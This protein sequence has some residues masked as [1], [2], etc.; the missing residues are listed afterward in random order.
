LRRAEE[1]RVADTPAYS[2]FVNSTDNFEDTWEPFFH[3]LNDFWPQ[4]R[5]VILNTERKTFNHPDVPVTCTKVAREGETRIPWGEC[6][7][8]ALEHISTETFVYL[9]DDYFLYRAVKTDVVDEAART[10]DAENL[11]CLR[12]MECG[13]AGPYEPTAYPWLCSVSR[14]ATYRISLQAALWTKAGMRKYLRSHESPWQMEVWGSKRA[15]RTEGRIWAVNR[16]VYSENHTQVI[17]Y[18]PTGIVRGQWKRDIVEK[19]FAEHGIDVPFDVRGWLTPGGPPR[20]SFT[21][22]L[23][24]LPKFAWDRVRSL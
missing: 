3:L 11:D 23:G 13:E 1:R 20:S 14:T 8:R 17:P 4:T 9:Q 19:L 10:V 24:K 15:G 21:Q 6:M 2:I 7:L 18:V 12:L 5:P 16:D 22:K